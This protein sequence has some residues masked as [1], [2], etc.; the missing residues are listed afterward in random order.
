MKKLLILFTVLLAG[1][2]PLQAA[3]VE[4]FPACEPGLVPKPCQ[5][6]DPDFYPSAPMHGSN[7]ALT[8][9]TIALP[10]ILVVGVAA[11]ILSVSDSDTSH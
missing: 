1:I 8:F 6:A 4:E 10:I 5:P 9:A 11:V 2:A 7:C 3:H